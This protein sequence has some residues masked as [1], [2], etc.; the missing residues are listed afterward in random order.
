MDY[1][2]P[3]KAKLLPS[4]WEWCE[5]VE[6]MVKHGL[7]MVRLDQGATGHIRRKP[8][9]LLTSLKPLLQLDGLRAEGH[10][11]Q[12]LEQELPDRLRQS[13]TWAQWSDGL[14]EAIRLAIR[15]LIME[16]EEPGVTKA[17]LTLA[18]WRQHVEQNHT[19]YRRDCRLCLERMGQDKPHRRQRQSGDMAFNMSVDIAGPFCSG[20]D[21][22]YG[23]GMKYGLLATVPIPVGRAK[24][25]KVEKEDD[26]ETIYADEEGNPVPEGEV[27]EDPLQEVPEPVE[28][29]DFE[30]EI[31]PDHQEGDPPVDKEQIKKDMQAATERVTVQN[32][33]LF[34]PLAS[35][36]THEVIQGLDRIWAQYRALGIQCYRFHSDRARE[37]VAKPVQQWIA[38]H[39]MIQTVTEGDDAQSNGRIESELCQWK[40]RLRLTLA[41]AQADKEEWPNIGRQVMEERTRA[42]LQRL[43][44]KPVGPMIPYNTKVMV[45]TKKWHKR[46][47][48]GLANPY[49]AAVCKGP[50]P[51][52]SSGWIV[53]DDQGRV[54]HTRFALIPD[55]NAD[56]AMLE[57]VEKTEAPERRLHGKQPLQPGRRLPEQQLMPVGTGENADVQDGEEEVP[58]KGQALVSGISRLNPMAEPGMAQTHVADEEGQ[59]KDDHHSGDKFGGPQANRDREPDLPPQQE[60]ASLGQAGGSGKLNS[61][62]VARPAVKIAQHP[63]QSQVSQSDLQHGLGECE[64]CGLLQPQGQGECRMCATKIAKVEVNGE[65]EGQRSWK[66]PTSLENYEEQLLARHYGWAE[67]MKEEMSGVPCCEEDVD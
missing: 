24:E 32:V 20:W 11:Q 5:V 60:T 33:T 50:S 49:L 40:R 15:A 4:I 9:A 1:V 63:L 42:Q 55:P 31:E 34:E 2:T 53:R 16:K 23:Q 13:A 62:S 18:E 22:G 51:L 28:T 54:H 52:M 46:A 10:G 67:A 56:R 8:T 37:F 35:R 48:Q 61:S 26:N 19:P 17:R 29:T 44:M 66:L 47:S 6:F 7:V 64:G 58:E 39:G 3:E 25:E 21:F 65:D 14:V 59:R 36:Q 45:R 43:G 30:E 38:K 41:S 57:L 12:E 27:V